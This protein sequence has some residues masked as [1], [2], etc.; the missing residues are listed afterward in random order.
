[1]NFRCRSLIPGRCEFN[2]TGM[3]SLILASQSKYRVQLLKRLNYPF[4]AIAPLID[5]EVLKKSA[6]EE[7]QLQALFLAKAKAQS[8]FESTNNQSW[9]IGSDQL[10]SFSG[11]I[12]G[13][14]HTQEKAQQQLLELQGSTHSL[15]TAVTLLGP[16]FEQSWVVE[17]KLTMRSLS[18]EQIAHYL[19]LDLPFDCAGSYKLEQA[20]ISLFDHIE[21]Q[22]WTAIEGLPL[23]S[24]HQVLRASCFK[25][26]QS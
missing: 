23:I 8:V 14:A 2:L 7:S 17:A 12:F 20:G 10:L 5:E 13:K 9:V 19:A 26:G 6:P 24:L 18:H 22:D 21:C 11:K 25:L 3:I 15:I 1:M 16:A 4:K